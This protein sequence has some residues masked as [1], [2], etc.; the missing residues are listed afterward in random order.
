MN[1]RR[2]AGQDTPATGA[3]VM[4]AGWTSTSATGG[5]RYAFGPDIHIG[6]CRQPAESCTAFEI[7]LE[8]KSL[9]RHWWQLGVRNWHVKRVRTLGAL[10]AIAL[11]VGAVVWVTCC[12]ESVRETVMGWASGYVGRSH[13]NIESPFGKFSQFAQRRVAEVADLPEVKSVTP[14]LVERLRGKAVRRA[15]FVEGTKYDPWSSP[16]IDFTG[17]DLDS[18]PLVR[19]HPIVAGR[20][21]TA[22]D[23]YAV[24]LEASYAR[25]EGVGPGDYLIIWNESGDTQ[26]KLEIV[27]LTERRRIARF[28]PPLALLRL[29][30]LQQI[31][32][33]YGFITSLDVVLHDGGRTALAQATAK[34]RR[35]TLANNAGA[36]VRSAE[37]RLKQVELAQQQQEVVL[38]L[39]SCVAMLTALFIILSTL[40]M[41]MLE[42]I[43]QLGLLRC[44]GV[45]ASQ[46]AGLVYLEVLPLGLLGIALGIPLGLGLTGLTVK[47]VPEYVGRFAISWDGIGLAAIA[48]FATTLIAAT[49]PAMAAISVS[50]LEASRPRARRPRRAPLIAATLLGVGLLVAQVAIMAFKIGR[51]FEFVRWSAA[52]VVLLYCVYALAAP[53]MV[54]LLGSPAVLLIA[55]L[56]GVRARL[57]QDQVGHAV[58]RSAGIVCG[59][60]VGLSLIVALVVL[61]RSFRAGWQFPK[62]FPEAYIWSYEQFGITPEE[63]ARRIEQFAGVK[64]F[65]LA[66]ALNMAVE[67]RQM[68]GPRAQ[69]FHSATWFLGCDPDTFLDMVKFE[70]IEG[71]EE[72]AR[73]LLRQGGHV[74]VSI[75]FARSRHKGLVP[76]EARGISNTVRVWFSDL[77]A[78]TFKIAGVID[79]PALDIAA[80][81]FQAESEARVAAM[82]SMIGSNADLKRFFN[83]DTIKLVL[84]NFDL[85]PEPPPPNWPPP[86]EQA[87]P[88][89]RASLNTDRKWWYDDDVPLAVRWQRARE[90]ELL[91]ELRN[92]LDAHSAYVG[93]ASELKDHIDAE[94]TRVTYLLTAIPAVALLV[95]AI[96][97]ANL[98][99][100]NVASRSKQLAILRAVGATRG[101]ILRMVVGEA[102][103]LAAIGSALGLALGLHL[104]KNV[105]QMT[106]RFSGFI[107]PLEIPWAFVGLAVALTISLCLLAGILPARH[108][109]RTNVIEAL[110]VA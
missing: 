64:N 58:W 49:L 55:R 59:L 57:L 107:G 103:V 11:G 23:H 5:R 87:G 86:P 102:L 37:A 39:L 2:R 44:V 19:D 108:A 75:D 41:G 104:A 79:S 98:M 28:Q 30:V 33:K 54:W 10:L 73:E 50:P 21:L 9:I 8:S 101:Q 6:E 76:D 109:S 60:M 65:A 27:G 1:G 38:A 96:G 77:G 48:G 81:F 26:Q 92:A 93:T 25:E 71:D 105:Q 99:T 24:V 3:D 91:L 83:I 68:Q 80:S 97:V 43:S 100:A 42:R 67:E 45:T 29:P 35:I 13:I 52:S 46:L 4:R 61:N 84:L 63:A 18:E 22:A 70:F 106:L 82:G 40:S 7:S 95:A 34:I 69:I 90:H 110:H 53:L 36:H 31:D 20:G 51:N 74:L 47:A 85:P 89:L 17:I 12:Y 72:T 14:L 32:N 88:E 94:L 62:Q 15:D 56:V 16:E 66:N 78:R